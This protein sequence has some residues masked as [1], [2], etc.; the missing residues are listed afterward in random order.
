MLHYKIYK[1]NNKKSQGYG[2]YYARTTV[3]ETY[4][5][6]KLAEHMANHNTPFSK[7]AIQ[8]V[9]T[10]MVSCIRE[11]VLDGNA[12]KLPNLAIFSAGIKSTPADKPEDFDPTKNIEKTYLR[13]RSTGTLMTAALTA[14]AKVRQQTNYT[15]PKSATTTT[16]P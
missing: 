1:N 16:N 6:N 7:G 9:L 8:G 11:I 3:G 2:K 15:T 5:L 12:V 10:D 13:A 4:D 14:S